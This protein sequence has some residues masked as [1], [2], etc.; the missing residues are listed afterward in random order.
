LKTPVVFLIFR[1][2]DLTAR[3][4]ET[5]RQAQP[6]KLLIVADGA[7]NEEEAILC[8]QTRA[9][10]EQIDWDCEVLRNYSDV[11]LGCRQRISS[12]ITWTF[13]QV[14]EAIILEDD[15]LPHPSFFSYCENLLDYYRDDE[16]IMVISGDNFQDGNQRTPYS[17]YFSKYNHCWG[18]ATWRRA[19]KHWH[20]NPETWIEFRDTGLIKFICD[21]S[22]EEKYWTQVFNTLFLEGK[23]NT[24]D[25]PWTFACWSQSGL[26]AL[27]NVNLVSNIGFGAGGTHTFGDSHLANM[28]VEDIGEITHPPFVVRHIEGDRYTFDH[29]F[30]GKSMK[31]ADAMTYKLKSYLSTFRRRCKRLL[32]E[33]QSVL[34]LVKRLNS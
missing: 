6:A 5:I 10:T 31:E 2:P 19:W 24:W 21:D 16:R 7:R 22:Y 33:P 30:G 34:D 20:F 25:Y 27:P 11:N 4:F 32:S 29:H 12:G 26:T 9:V 17:Y 18:W 23:P 28:A 13:E 14:E 1:R 3:V 15:C 8:Q